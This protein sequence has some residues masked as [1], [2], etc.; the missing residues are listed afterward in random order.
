ME[1]ANL[2]NRRRRIVAMLGGATGS[3]K[4][5]VALEVAQRLGLE[6]LSADSGQARQGLSIGTAMPSPADIET[7]RHHLV[8]D[9]PADAQDSVALYLDRAAAVLHSPGPDLLA[10]GGTGQ[11]LQALRDGLAPTPPP[12][13]DLRREL[14]E[15][16]GKEG[17]EAL[18][19]ELSTRTEPPPDAR[20]NPVRLL[21]ALE[22]SILLERGVVGE[23]RPPLAAQAP[24]FALVMDRGILRLRQ[25][26]RLELMLASGWREEV[27]VLAG[28]VSPDAPCWKCIGYEQLR[29]TL[30]LPVLP[31]A[32]TR[33]ILEATRQYAKRQETW[34]RN[35]LDPR[36]IDAD[37]PAQAIAGDILNQLETLP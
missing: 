27:R 15:R 8:A 21:R 4:T 37:R 3:G 25:E 7:V 18:W 14:S 5:A 30:H 28:S 2:G 31:A 29:E 23:S 12:D 9:I 35:R 19:T 11:F 33:W 26:R 6:I 10:V 17:A 34:L 13:P 24:I 32:T 36:W 22:K 1:C 20:R 16:L